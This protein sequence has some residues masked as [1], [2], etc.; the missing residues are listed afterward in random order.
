MINHLLK[1]PRSNKADK[2]I[3]PYCIMSAK[4]LLWT[5][6]KFRYLRRTWHPLQS[7]SSSL[8]TSMRMKATS[9]RKT[10]GLRLTKI[11]A[12]TPSQIRNLHQNRECPYLTMK[13]SRD[14]SSRT[15]VKNLTHYNLQSRSKVRSVE[16]FCDRLTKHLRQTTSKSN[17]KKLKFLD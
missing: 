15:K 12:A 13:A 17:L 6:I 2:Y 10:W 7:I 5:S 16:H 3:T 1:A 14:L 4:K 8:V 9:I 11:R